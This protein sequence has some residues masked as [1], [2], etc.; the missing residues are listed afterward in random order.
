MAST[1]LKLT[2]GKRIKDY[3][4]SAE[5]RQNDLANRLG[6][7]GSAV[8]QMIHGKIVP[9]HQQLETICELLALD[10]PK[11]FELYSLLSKIRTG[12][13]EMLSP[14]NQ[15]M[16][17]LRCQRGLSQR[18]LSNLSGISMSHL[19]M[20]ETCFDAIPTL[21][22]ARQ[23]A[24]ILGCT[25]EALLQSA[26]IAVA[27][28]CGNRGIQSPAEDEV[29]ESFATYTPSAARQIALLSL[30]DLEEYDGNTPIHEY[31]ADHAARHMESDTLNYENIVAVNIVGKDLSL[32]LPGSIQLLLSSE[33]PAGFREIDLCRAESG[34]YSLQEWKNGRRREF[35]LAGTR[36]TCEPIVWG[37]PV[38]ELTFRPIK[39]ELAGTER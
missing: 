11:A 30:F 22:E 36:R 20:F 21:D 26:G 32:G 34:R 4:R 2:L 6:L 13:E 15:L 31:A 8:S 7:S 35:R 33:R 28:P 9:N 19:Q 25:P 29:C 17:S 37:V 14:F 1:P 27:V 12:A 23:I 39:P 38:L 16:F 10:R 18:Q 3:L 5:L 24:P